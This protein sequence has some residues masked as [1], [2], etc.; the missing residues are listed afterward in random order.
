MLIIDGKNILYSDIL[1]LP[2]LAYEEDSSVCT[3]KIVTNQ[4]GEFF[5]TFESSEE[6]NNVVNAILTC[7]PSLKP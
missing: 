2:T 6:R 4:E 3:L 5:L 7:K 1:S